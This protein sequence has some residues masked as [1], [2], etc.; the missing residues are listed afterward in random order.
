VDP[1]KEEGGANRIGSKR[2]FSWDPC[3][4][5][6]AV[7]LVG[8][9]AVAIAING[10]PNEIN[11]IRKKKKKTFWENKR[12]Q[13][14]AERTRDE[15]QR[16]QTIPALNTYIYFY[17]FVRKIFNQFWTHPSSLTPMFFSFF[18]FHLLIS[19]SDLQI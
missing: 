17:L 7:S 13:R 18:S 4:G 3:R 14:W 19:R 6:V 12:E 5:T 10:N 2:R 15:R 11:G 9:K 1:R 16:R 8:A